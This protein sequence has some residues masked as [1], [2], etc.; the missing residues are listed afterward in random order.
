[1]FAVL[2]TDHF[3]EYTDR[4]GISRL[5]VDVGSSSQASGDEFQ[6]T[7]SSTA[8]AS[9]P[10]LRITAPE[11]IDITEMEMT[12]VLG[13]VNVQVFQASAGTPGGTFTAAPI[14][15][16]NLRNVKAPSFSVASG[17][18]FTPS[19]AALRQMVVNGGT[20]V[21]P[22]ASVNRVNRRVLSLPAGTYYIVTGLLAGVASLTAE[23][24]VTIVDV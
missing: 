17:G 5:K 8:V 3:I 6:T 24:I 14:Q 10:V 1:M 23:L 22:L 19:A 20:A 2:R 21:A 16:T 13:G 7:Q 9:A 18:T 15:S 4:T 12:V 11:P